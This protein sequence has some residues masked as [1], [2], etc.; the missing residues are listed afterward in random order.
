MYGPALVAAGTNCQA[1]GHVKSCCC[2]IKVGVGDG[3]IHVLQLRRIEN[4]PAVNEVPEFDLVLS[5]GVRLLVEP[6][7][8]FLKLGKLF[9]VFA[10]P[11]LVGAFGPIF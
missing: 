5:Q 1:V 6:I 2:H 4:L 3:T 10:L 7:D 8:A 11:R 9:L